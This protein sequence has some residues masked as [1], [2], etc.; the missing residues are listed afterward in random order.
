MAVTDERLTLSQLGEQ[1]GWNHRESDRTDVYTRG[2]VRVR[3]IW[4]GDS[5]ISG[6]SYFVD[7]LYETYTRELNKV[8][9]WLKR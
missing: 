9:T 7:E 3:V 5:K 2:A 4:Q 6:A 8:Q 1:Q